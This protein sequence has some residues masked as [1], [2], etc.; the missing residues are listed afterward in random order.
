MLQKSVILIVT[1]FLMAF[2]VIGN[3]QSGETSVTLKDLI[4][5]WKPDV[6]GGDHT[7]I[8][9]FNDDGS[10]RM[11][12]KVD[13]LDTR[14]IDKG[15]VRLE[16][17]QVTFFSSES[18]TCKNEIGKYT[19]GMIEKGTFR[20]TMQEDPCVSRSSVFVSEWDLIN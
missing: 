16:G 19:I 5:I 12:W 13:R 8:I 3:S 6:S 9:K 4:G 20:L 17:K 10:F 7:L 2:L 15:Q 1:F 11:A 14:P 18:L